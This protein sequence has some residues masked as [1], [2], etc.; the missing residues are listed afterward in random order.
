MSAKK[1]Q[2]E[3]LEAAIKELMQH[4]RCISNLE[5]EIDEKWG[6]RIRTGFIYPPNTKWECT[7]DCNVV[8]GLEEIEKALGK[9]A[10][11]SGCFHS[12]RELRHYGIEF[13]Q[14]AD[15]KTKVFVKAGCQPPKVR[16]VEDTE[17]A[18]T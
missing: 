7:A 12:T 2:P 3:T 13:R 15:D 14:H 1:M 16:F 9:E 17:D 18:G 8:R 4:I 5:E 6:V 11:Q 10:N